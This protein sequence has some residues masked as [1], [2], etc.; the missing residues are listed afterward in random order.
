LVIF[1]KTDPSGGDPS[2][3]MAV[4]GERWVRASQRAP[5]RAAF[6]SVV[7]RPLTAHWKVERWLGQALGAGGELR[8]PGSGGG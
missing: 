5:P 6:W 3:G 1:A 2:E 7:G 8:A 4:G